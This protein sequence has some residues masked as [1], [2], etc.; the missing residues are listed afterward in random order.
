MKTMEITVTKL[1]QE[2]Y[3]WIETTIRSA[4]KDA[5]AGLAQEKTKVQAD[6]DEVFLSAQQAA[7]FLKIK[8]NTIYSKVEKRDLPH[9]RS[10]KRKL[11]F[12]KKELEEYISTRKGKTVND[13][14]K[15]V[16]KY[17]NDKRM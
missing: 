4:I 17:L 9:Y 10:G 11:L 5:M 12:S 14:T 8:L 3:E 7:D 6:A 13:I 2:I 1:S 15:E 16:T